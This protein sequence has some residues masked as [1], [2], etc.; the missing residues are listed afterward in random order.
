MPRTRGRGRKA[1]KSKKRDRGRRLTLR[2]RTK[3][4]RGGYTI[5]VQGENETTEEFENRK[6]R[7]EANRMESARL[8]AMRIAE[9]A[10]AKQEAQMA[11]AKQEAQMAWEER[12]RL[13]QE[14]DARAAKTNPVGCYYKG[15]KGGEFGI[16]DYRTRYYCNQGDSKYPNPK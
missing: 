11:A 3:N 5:E 6:H 15:S 1:G 2:V 12:R 8:Q 7:L 10:A 16:P 4:R 14:E 13:A 9:I